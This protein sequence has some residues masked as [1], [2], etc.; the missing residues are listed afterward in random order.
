MAPKPE[1]S[2][3]AEIIGFIGLMLVVVVIMVGAL[4]STCGRSHARD[5]GQWENGDP[6]IRQWY[7]SLMRPDAPSSSCCGE[8]DAY[9]C[10]NFRYEGK[11][12]VCTITDDRD[13]GPLGRPHVELGTVIE[14]PDVKLKWDK[15][16]PTGHGVVFMSWQGYVLCYVQGGGA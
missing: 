2:F 14:V 15:G 12:A 10:D 13:D 4:L 6:A 9:W 8:A 16:N 5:L 3:T 1:H 11:R 7:K